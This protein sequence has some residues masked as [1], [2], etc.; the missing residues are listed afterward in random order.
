MSGIKNFEDDV[1]SFMY[2]NDSITNNKIHEMVKQELIKKK[3]APFVFIE[4]IND[5]NGLSI[6]NLDTNE[7]IAICKGLINAGYKDKFKLSDY[8][9]TNEI[10]EYETLVIVNE[11]TLLLTFDNV[12]KYNDQYYVCPCWQPSEQYKARKNRLVRYNFAT[13][14]EATLTKDSYG[15]VR[16]EITLNKDSVKGIKDTILKKEYFPPDT[17]TLNVLLLEDKEPN[18][19]YDENKKKLYIKINYNIEDYNYTVVDF[20]DGWHRDSAIYDLYNEGVNVEKYFKGFPVNISI[21]TA[22]QSAAFVRRQMLANKESD[23]YL[24]SIENTEYNTFIDKINKNIE[25]NLLYGNISKTRDEMLATDTLTYYDIF[26]KALRHVE[27]TENIEI[28]GRRIQVLGTKKYINIVNTI[29]EELNS[30]N[31]NTEDLKLFTRE[32]IYLGYFAI[33]SYL[34]KNKLNEE[35]EFLLIEKFVKNMLEM[36][37]EIKSLRL[38]A[39]NF[40]INKTYELFKELI[41]L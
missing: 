11:N 14:R 5:E 24:R 15:K 16:R 40:V 2:G 35:E 36:K 41:Q 4:V 1:L 27:K 7:Q 23:E 17:L 31:V 33:W 12:E 39:K 19:D 26:R 8:F 37:N 6:N 18:I 29:V 25:N 9:T 28:K 30:N 10:G 22:K 21:T 13:Q 3:L 34:E 20:T 38:G 32:G